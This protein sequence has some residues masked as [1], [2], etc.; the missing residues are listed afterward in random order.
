VPLAGQAMH[1]PGHL[2]DDALHLFFLLNA[3]Q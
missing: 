3:Q 1:G 2:V